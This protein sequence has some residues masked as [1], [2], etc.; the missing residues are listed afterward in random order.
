MS[1]TVVSR[2]SDTVVFDQSVRGS[3]ETQLAF[4]NSVT[5]G[6]QSTMYTSFQEFVRTITDVAASERAKLLNQMTRSKIAAGDVWKFIA[7]GLRTEDISSTFSTRH[8]SRTAYI[9]H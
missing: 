9:L 6:D 2:V 3:N 8:H 4:Q 7:N 5:P 1:G